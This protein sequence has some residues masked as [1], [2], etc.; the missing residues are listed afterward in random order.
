MRAIGVGKFA[1]LPAIQLHDQH[2]FDAEKVHDV[3]ADRGLPP[4]L[5]TLEAAIPNRHPEALFYVRLVTSETRG[6]G[7]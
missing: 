1:M 2:L 5:E 3:V 7:G 4:E 6:M